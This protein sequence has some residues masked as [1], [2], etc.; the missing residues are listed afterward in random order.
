MFENRQWPCQKDNADLKLQFA[1]SLLLISPDFF[2][3]IGFLSDTVRCAVDPQH[4]VS[5]VETCMC[6][7]P[8]IHREVY[9]PIGLPSDLVR[10][11]IL[12]LLSLS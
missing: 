7:C 2:E 4:R 3:R 12:L 5:G 11:L 6:A 8:Y 10:L 9:F 1:Q